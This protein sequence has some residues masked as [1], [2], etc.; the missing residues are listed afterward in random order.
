MLDS[1][2][3]GNIHHTICDQVNMEPTVALFESIVAEYDLQRFDA[4]IAAGGGSVLDTAKALA[5]A[6]SF[7]GDIRD[8]AGFDKVPGIPRIPVLAV[9]TTSGTGSEVSDGSVLIDEENNTKFLVISKKICPTD[10]ITDPEMTLSMPPMVTALS[11]TDALVHATES[12]IS[13][14]PARPQKCSPSRR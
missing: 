2:E 4:I 11:G 5:V 7:G 6:H 12:Y 3:A 13:K 1:L 8:Y 14:G 9:P 10:A